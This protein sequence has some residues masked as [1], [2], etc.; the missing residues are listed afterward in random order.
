[1]AVNGFLVILH[2]ITTG[3]IQNELSRHPDFRVLSTSIRR[4]LSYIHKIIK[5]VKIPSTISWSREM[6]WF[7]GAY[8]SRKHLLRCRKMKSSSSLEH[9][10]PASSLIPVSEYLFFWYSTFR[11]RNIFKVWNECGQIRPKKTHPWFHRNSELKPINVLAGRA[12]NMYR[13]IP[14]CKLNIWAIRKDQT[15]HCNISTLFQSHIN[16]KYYR[17]L[18]RLVQ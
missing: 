12:K 9:K 4:E 15:N 16:S 5:I 13:R 11:T 1:M 17:D 10:S 18:F 6:A 2:V 8:K 7:W 3:K 14:S